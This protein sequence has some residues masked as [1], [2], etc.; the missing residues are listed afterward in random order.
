MKTYVNHMNSRNGCD[1][2]ENVSIS[3]DQMSG[4]DGEIYA[5]DR[6]IV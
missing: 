3:S 5:S 6:E 4:T 2:Y 1:R